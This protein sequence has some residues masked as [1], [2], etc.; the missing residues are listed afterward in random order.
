MKMYLNILINQQVNQPI[1]HV[2]TLHVIS[3]I[4]YTYSNFM[5]Y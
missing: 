3:Y 5:V 4:F 2:S 1:T